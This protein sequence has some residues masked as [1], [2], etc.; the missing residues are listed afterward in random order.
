MRPTETSIGADNVID[1]TV[2]TYSRIPLMSA[3][4]V[5]TRLT[6]MTEELPSKEG[7]APRGQRM[8]RG[9]PTILEERPR[10]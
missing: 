1:Y 6:S 3:L 2:A 8:S 7:V 4:R 5:L 9:T 10:R